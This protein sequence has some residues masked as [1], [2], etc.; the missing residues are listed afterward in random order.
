MSI[1]IPGIRYSNLDVRYKSKTANVAKTVGSGARENIS[2]CC[3]LRPVKIGIKEYT[4]KL[5]NNKT[6]PIMIRHGLS[7]KTVNLFFIKPYHKIN[8][9]CMINPSAYQLAT[10]WI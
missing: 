5:T 4:S 8:S 9:A 1:Q 2:N 3:Q 7:I 10:T 6:E